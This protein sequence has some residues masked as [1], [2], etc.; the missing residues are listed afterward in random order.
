MTMSDKTTTS[1]GVGEVTENH[2]MKL[3]LCIAALVAGT[4]LLLFSLVLVITW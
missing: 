4:A 1:P 3:G 2:D